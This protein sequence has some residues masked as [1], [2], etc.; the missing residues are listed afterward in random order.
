MT[1]REFVDIARERW[2]SVV[3]GLLLGVLAGVLATYLVPREYSAS[4]TMIVATQPDPTVPAAAGGDE[5]SAQRISTYV[6]LMRS[7]RLAGEVIAVLGLPETPE[8]LADRISVTTTPDSALIT[9]AVTDGESDRA[10]RIANAIGDAFI[11]DVAAIEQPADPVRPPTVVAKV[12]Q[13]AQSPADLVAPR[14][15]LYVLL[16]IVI[17]LLLGF[18]AAVVRSA[19][20][21]RIKSRSQLETTFGVPVLG[22][23]GRDRKVRSSPLRIYGA[24]HTP[25]AEAFR[26]LR[27]N[28]QVLAVDRGHKVILVTSANPGEGRTTTVCNLGL[29]MAKAGARVV[30]VDADLRNP[31]VARYLGIPDSPGL[32]D[33]LE[34]GLSV[35]SAVHTVGQTLDALPSGLCPPNPSE[36]LGSQHMADLLA[37]LRKKYDVVLVDTAPLLPVTDAAVLALRVDAVLVVTRDGRT[38]VQEAEAARDALRVAS[39]RILGS[40]LTMARHAGP[41]RR[42]NLGSGSRRWWPGTRWSEN[43]MAHEPEDVTTTMPVPAARERPQPSPQPS[44]RPRSNGD[45]PERSAVD[46][47]LDHDSAAR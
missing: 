26:Q 1:P 14:P 12:F 5:V 3:V 19:L 32:T 46:E 8:Q 24:S 36:L 38:R 18:G 35:E 27:T 31:S 34:V 6:E 9:A 22:A 44:P 37:S 7:R 39:V 2:R 16:G 10:V 42:G 15:A 23:I 45:G 40:V 43:G 4:V 28:V 47:T 30:V 29:A 11:K 21:T 20:D 33:V 41:R 17:G 25:L 13:A